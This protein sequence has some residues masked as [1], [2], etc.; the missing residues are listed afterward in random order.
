MSVTS[1][2]CTKLAKRGITK[3]T[4]HDSQGLYSFMVEKITTK[5]RIAQTIEISVTV[6]GRQLIQPPCLL[7]LAASSRQQVCNG[8]ASVRPSV[9]WR[10]KTLRKEKPAVCL[11]C[12]VNV[13]RQ[14]QRSVYW[15]QWLTP[16]WAWRTHAASGMQSD[17]RPRH[18]DL[19]GMPLAMNISLQSCKL[20]RTNG[21]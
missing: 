3:T 6:L 12:V 11:S 9:S 17:W 8:L 19:L 15:H 4:P 1:R 18:T 2:C 14:L 20:P 10:R 21:H 16:V 13:S 7:P 5:F